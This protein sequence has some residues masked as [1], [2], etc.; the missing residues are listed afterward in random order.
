MSDNGNKLHGRGSAYQRPVALG[1]DYAHQ[2]GVLHQDVKPRTC[3]RNS[4]R[5]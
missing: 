3:W 4:V 1:L 5:R 2:E